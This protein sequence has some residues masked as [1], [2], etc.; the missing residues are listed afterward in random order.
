MGRMMGHRLM[1]VKIASEPWEFEQIHTLNHETFTREIPQHPASPS[2]RLV[3]RFHDDNV[4]V[5]GLHDRR[6]AGMVAIRR[7]RPFS[8]DQR[9]PDLDAYLPAGRAICELRLLAV[10]KGDRRRGRLLPAIFDFVWRYCLGQGYD[11]ALISG[12]TRQLKL[13]E[14]IGFMPFGPL[15]GAPGAL[16]QPMMLTLERFAP[17]APRLLHAAQPP[18][19]APSVSFL[20]GPAAVRPAVR[21]AF[22]AP[23]ESH[24]SAAFVADV[25]AVSASLCALVGAR[26]VAILLGSGTSANDAVAAQLSL[27]HARGVILANGEFGERLVDHARRFGLAFD[28]LNQPWGEPFD[29][30]AV[31]RKLAG[32]SPS[33]WL[34]FVHCET[35]TGVLNDLDAMKAICSRAG[36][37]LCVDA[38]SSIGNV[39]VD[40]RGVH[41]ASGVSGKGLGSFPG[42][43]MV[44][45]HDDIRPAPERLPRYLDIGL[46]AN[47]DGVPFTQSSNLVRALGAAVT[48]SDW[49][50]R[51]R[52]VD[53]ATRWLRARLTLLGLSIVARDDD[54]QSLRHAAPGVVTIALPDAIDSAAIGVAL[55]QQGFLVSVNSQYLLQR[56]W[57]QICLMGETS[58]EQ[59]AAVSNALYQLCSRVAAGV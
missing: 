36:A 14:H 56:N 54:R 16:F 19:H 10:E 15:V 50:A 24:R 34:W 20:P 1:Q 41:L 55:Q 6:V 40:F 32:R 22:E 18:A 4:Y 48:A 23:A 11:L 47:A 46:Y 26:R 35:S 2:G 21:R 29:L 3:D 27:R 52:A 42:L 30:E 39:P 51:F 13:Y 45:Y 43:A 57:I 31:T 25:N 44:F 37:V 38:I 33:G 5:I 7:Q 17:R 12:T 9:L 28:V 58:R 53:E 59:L 8:L 49:P